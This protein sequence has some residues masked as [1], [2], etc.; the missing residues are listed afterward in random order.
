MRAANTLLALVVAALV[1]AAPASAT[2]DPSGY[3]TPNGN[4]YWSQNWYLNSYGSS[5]TS[6]R[7]AWGYFHGDLK[8]VQVQ[9]TS[10]YY[11]MCA[12]AKTSSD[13]GG[14]NA[15]PMGEP[16]STS[17]VKF[18]EVS[19]APTAGYGTMI[20]HDIIGSCCFYADGVK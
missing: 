8:L 1:V 7:G 5:G 12:G 13:G 19:S 6:D 18:F 10:W 15:S 17:E 14:Y 3:C 16:C 2:F 4:C 20:N 9:N 11:L